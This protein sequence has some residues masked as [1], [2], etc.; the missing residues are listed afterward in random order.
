MRKK[1]I[2]IVLTLVF[3]LVLTACGGKA[4]VEEV[5]ESYIAVEIETLDRTELYI[6]NVFSGK[7]FADKDVNVNPLV[8][9]DVETVNV[10]VGDYVDKDQLLF[11]LDGDNIQNQVDQAY[12]AYSAA[13]ASYEMTK[14]QIAMAKDSFERTKELYD[15]GV[16]SKAQYDQAELAAS[17]RPL[18]TAEKG[19]DQARLGYNQALDALDNVEVK[20]PISGT[21]TSVNVETGEMASGG[22]SAV[23]IMDLDSVVIE[24][25]V[26]ENIVN[27]IY[28]GQKVNLQVE[29]AGIDTE[30][31]IL[32][33]SDS[34]DMMN[35]LYP[36][37]IS[38]E[39]NGKVKAG[40]FAQV[41][42][43]T[44]LREDVISIP[45][46]AVL[47]KDGNS[48]VYV[49]VEGIAYEKTVETGLDTGHMVEIISGLED[50]ERIITKGQNYISDGIK[51]KV[52]RGE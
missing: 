31:V 15:E 12:A 45:G 14:E 26:P 4:E 5:E 11:T 33:V 43:N 19:L 10:K 39:N 24:I 44:D 30:A 36:V 9:A 3:T 8:M 18:E 6:E 13:M 16:V 50:G 20:A 35:N 23:V 22:Q 48:I 2:L 17:D 28:E 51:V 7:V 34:V 1:H 52:V 29:S 47:E 41:T 46:D 42:V 37:T 49:E 25:N 21:V 38:A 32:S 40:M 27:K